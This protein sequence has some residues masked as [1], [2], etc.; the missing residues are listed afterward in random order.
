MT[1][2]ILKSY[3]DTTEKVEFITKCN[4]PPAHPESSDTLRTDTGQRNR[5]TVELILSFLR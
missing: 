1:R 3:R 4:A 2:M 5:E